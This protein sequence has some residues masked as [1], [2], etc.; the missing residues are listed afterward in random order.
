LRARRDSADEYIATRELC[1]PDLRQERALI[2]AYNVR[3]AL[4]RGFDKWLKSAES[5]TSFTA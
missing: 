3:E 2:A 1:E 5:R 4:S